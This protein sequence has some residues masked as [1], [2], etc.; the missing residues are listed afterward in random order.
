M[1]LALDIPSGTVIGQSIIPSANTT[2]MTSFQRADNAIVGTTT[3]A[4]TAAADLPVTG[5]WLVVVGVTGGTVQ[6]MQ[7]SEI[8]A[9]NT[10]LI[11][12]RFLM[13]YRAI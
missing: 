5:W 7:S 8:A 10:T 12:G 1:N 3:A 9:S 13:Q 4:A 6:L 11:G 2:L